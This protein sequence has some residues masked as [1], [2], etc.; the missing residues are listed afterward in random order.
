M[1][2]SIIIP[3]YNEEKRIAKT[4]SE[5]AKY[6]NKRVDLGE[7]SSYELLVVI[8]GTTDRTEDIVKD[9]QRG[10][11][12]I[13]YLFLKQGSKGFAVLEGF[14]DVL[15]RD[16]Q[17]IGFVDADMATPP[18]A[19]YDLVRKIGPYDV[20][21][22]NRH[23]PYSHI[24]T[25]FKRRVFSKG[26]N[27]VVKVLLGL[28]YSDTQCGAKMFRAKSI[29]SVTKIKQWSKWA[30]DVELLFRLKN[31]GFRVIEV[32]TEWVDRAGSSINLFRTPLQMFISIVRLRLLH[33][34]LKDLVKLYDRLPEKLKMHHGW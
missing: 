14:R 7:I 5:Y 16:T 31:A 10:N 17:L 20:A 12:N 18:H 30:F 6:F 29:R 2:L 8:N 11:K 26:F 27:L 9:I 28:P 24:T 23:S 1:E 4:L 34:F 21:I 13:R 3:A 32:P 22:A 19:F 33:S 25:S 15:K